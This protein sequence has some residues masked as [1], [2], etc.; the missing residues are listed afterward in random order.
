MCIRSLKGRL[1]RCKWVRDTIREINL[2]EDPFEKRRLDE[3]LK[4]HYRIW[5]VK[6]PTLPR[7]WISRR[8]GAE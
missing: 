5:G 8:K 3:M 2:T 6:P 7:E 1:Y 4:E